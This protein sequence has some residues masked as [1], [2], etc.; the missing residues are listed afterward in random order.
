M[1]ANGLL[2]LLMII[3]GGIVAAVTVLGLIAFL[4]NS[5]S[6]NPADASNPKISYGT[7]GN[8]SG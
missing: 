4:V 3:I 5:P 8:V 1:V 2:S 7:V 6:D